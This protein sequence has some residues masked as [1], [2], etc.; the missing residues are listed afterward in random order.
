MNKFIWLTF[1]AVILIVGACIPTPPTESTTSTTSTVTTTSTTVPAG[2]VAVSSAAELQSVIASGGAALVTSSITITDT[3][4]PGPDSSI[5]FSGA[6]VLYRPNTSAGPVIDVAADNVKLTNLQV[7]GTN[8]CIGTNTLPYNP[9]SVGEMYGAYGP[10]TLGEPASE[11]DHG[12]RVSSGSNLLI[13]GGNIN[14]VW[15]DGVYFEGGSNATIR[16]LVVRCGGRGGIVAVGVDGLD[17]FGGHISGTFWWALNFEPYGN[18]IVNDVSVQGTVIGFSRWPWLNAGGG[19]GG[20]CQVY[21]VN[22]NTVVL[23]P[24]STRPSTVSGCVYS[25]ITKPPGDF[26]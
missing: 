1:V 4:Y 13:D 17:V 9:D 25:E 2:E 5:R 21:D 18:H 22:L 3:V 15:G 12:V 19:E 7:T 6:G 14:K 26:N 20:N 8:E 24:Q 23:L 16:N 10:S 11:H